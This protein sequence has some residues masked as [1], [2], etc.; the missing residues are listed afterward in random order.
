MHMSRSQA[1]ALGRETKRILEL[2]HYTAPSGRTVDIADDVRRAVEA[3]LPY[4]PDEPVPRPRFSPVATRF[5]VVNETTLDAARRLVAEGHRPVAL[6]FASAKNPG[7][8][9]LNGARAQEESLC[10]ASAL[11]ACLLRQPMYDFHRRL[12]GGMYTSYALYSP[13]VPVFRTDEGSLLE[14][15]Y[16]CAFITA[17]AVNAKVV[18]G[19]EAAR[20]PAVFAAMQERVYKVLAIAAAHGQDAAVLGAWGC[21]VFGND[22]RE[23][24]ELF[25]REL[26]GAFHGA[27]ARV[28][29]AVVDWSADE[30]F[31]GPFRRAFS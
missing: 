27:F 29:F 22:P 20:H 16:L 23:I 24:A 9:F 8:G 28:V 17:P 5:E 11:S 25:R 30:H 14:V 13:D 10:R 19:R 21:G 1:A 15:P 2:G 7:G 6:N 4:P 12:G 26:T 3:T 18:L 31:I